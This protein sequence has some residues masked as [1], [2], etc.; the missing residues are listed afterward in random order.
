MSGLSMAVA[1]YLQ[2]TWFAMFVGGSDWAYPFVQATHFTGLSFWVGTNVLL[3][4]RLMGLGKKR[5]TAAQLA[6]NLFVWNWV[7]FAIAITGGFLLFSS[8]AT[9]YIPNPAFDLKLGFLLP[10]ALIL[11]V[12]V[13]SKAK[14][15]GQTQEVT[16]TGKIAGL[17]ELLFWIAVVTAAVS[18]PYFEA[19]QS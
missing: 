15:W 6:K 4:L 13:Q 8:S 9:T 1:R 7:G 16:G 2:S 5:E 3:D 11:H 19:S 17:I 10:I 12:W 18:I 14:D